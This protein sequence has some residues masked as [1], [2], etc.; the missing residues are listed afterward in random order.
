[1]RG[2]LLWGFPLGGLLVGA[3]LE[4]GNAVLHRGQGLRQPCF[5]GTQAFD[6]VL[7]RP[8]IYLL[9]PRTG[10]IEHGA[11]LALGGLVDA[12]LANQLGRFAPRIVDQALRFRVSLLEQAIPLR[13]E[14]ARL[15]YL[16]GQVLTDRLDDLSGS[17]D[18]DHGT[19]HTRNRPSG[20]DD[21]F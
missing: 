15:L 20:A 14:L 17:V 7:I 16:L 9:G 21:L 1:M 10:L 2:D 19:A 3:C 12:L 13:H 4:G 5:Q 6:G 11:G 18:V 8:G